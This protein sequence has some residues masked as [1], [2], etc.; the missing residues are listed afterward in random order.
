MKKIRLAK[1]CDEHCQLTV[2]RRA[3]QAGCLLPSRYSFSRSS[4]GSLSDR[5]LATC[6][7]SFNHV[8]LLFFV[9]IE[10]TSLGI[11]TEN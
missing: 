9:Q 11:P 6:Q 10:Q 8:F 4:S 7:C 1:G 2:F 5:R 3:K